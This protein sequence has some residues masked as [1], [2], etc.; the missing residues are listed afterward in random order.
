LVNKPYRLRTTSKREARRPARFVTRLTPRCARRTGFAHVPA[1]VQPAFILECY[2][3]IYVDLITWTRL[4]TRFASRERRPRYG[5]RLPDRQV[6]D[7]PDR[8]PPDIP[9]PGR[10]LRR[11]S[12]VQQHRRMAD[13][14]SGGDPAASR[15]ALLSPAGRERREHLHRLCLKAE[16]CA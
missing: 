5:C 13:V 9:V 2:N 1:A 15:P 3:L 8:A 16:P 7:R 10:H 11:R 6:P 12:G 4:R 14:D